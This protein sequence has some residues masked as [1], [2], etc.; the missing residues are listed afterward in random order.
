MCDQSEI[1]WYGMNLWS[2]YDNAISTNSLNFDYYAYNKD[3]RL[4]SPKFKIAIYGKAAEGSKV[5]LGSSD[6]YRFTY[7]IKSKILKVVKPALDKMKTDQG[8]TTGC[9]Y[10]GGRGKNIYVTLMWSSLSNEAVVRFM[11][12][13]KEKTILESDKVYIPIIEFFSLCDIFDQAFKSYITLC[14]SV[15]QEN[16]L[17]KLYDLIET[18]GSQIKVV[19]NE[20]GQ[21]ESISPNVVVSLNS[22][23]EVPA[24]DNKP[25]P[26]VDVSPADLVESE[27]QEKTDIIIKDIYN[28]ADD[29][30]NEEGQNDFDNFLKENRDNMELD[31]AKP[32]SQLIA[33]ETGEKVDPIPSRVEEIVTTS[34]FVDK[35]CQND[36]TKLEEIVINCCNEDLP[37]NA[38]VNAIKQFSDMDFEKGIDNKDY[39]ALN[40]AIS[41]QIKTRVGLL[42]EKQIKL[43]PSIAPVIVN[44][45][46]KNL[47]KIDA[48]YYLI[49]FY[50]YMSKVKTALSDKSNNSVDN[51][52]L[53]TYLLK[54]I[55]NPLLFAFM[56]DM[57]VE[58]TKS[59]VIRRYSN[60]VKNGFFNKFDSDIKSKINNSKYIIN[61]SDIEEAID[62]IYV[63]VEKFKDKLN[64][65]VLFDSNF[66]KLTYDDFKNN[67]VNIDNVRKIIKFDSS[68]FK[69][70]KID[71]NAL[72]INSTNELP[73]WI[74]NKFGIKTTKF[75]TT[76]IQKYFNDNYKGNSQLEHISKI[77]KNVYDILDS[78]DLNELDTKALRA[79]YFWDIDELPKT[80]TYVQFKNMIENS[81]L[82]KTELISMIGD[83][84]K[85]TDP[86][87][88]ASFL[89]SA[90]DP[91]ES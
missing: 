39:L 88:F 50:I 74:L 79:L 41:R 22:H 78:L 89:V 68:L 57:P 66:M 21:S 84:R 5:N 71:L 52:D 12:G 37:F 1:M 73:V 33:E 80:L 48:V 17:K 83:K 90:E 34:K 86:N 53:F 6:L 54:M 16:S 30:K 32:L 61:A 24:T 91:A 15:V 11:I 19:E 62:K 47:D 10:N 27:H 2:Y 51:K 82:E 23:F 45:T 20:V 65:S 3:E 8:Y 26:V 59:E 58:V 29:K 64:P 81:S 28:T 67:E 31:M 75:D 56:P 55:T 44:S 9:V 35:V 69:F 13:E 72:D 40:Y 77:N 85:V 60:L 38:F 42:I 87:F 18:N 14:S 25:L 76:I 63:N 70:K 46:D 7:L 4:A 36:F 49:L 43:P